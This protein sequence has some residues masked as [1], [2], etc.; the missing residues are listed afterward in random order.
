MIT[1]ARVNRFQFKKFLTMAPGQSGKR[2][3][4]NNRREQIIQLPSK[5]A[6]GACLPSGLQTEDQMAG[7][8]STPP[9]GAGRLPTSKNIEA[10][11]PVQ[12]GPR[13]KGARKFLEP[14]LE[15]AMESD[16]RRS[17]S[18]DESSGNEEE[19]E[20]SDQEQTGDA[21]NNSGQA[22]GQ[23]EQ[24]NTNEH[25]G[26]RQTHQTG[27]QSMPEFR[28]NENYI[29]LKVRAVLQGLPPDIDMETK[30]VK[31][32][33]AAGNTVQDTLTKKVCSNMPFSFL[34]SCS[35]CGRTLENNVIL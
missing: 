32:I 21:D 19:Q 28:E 23:E 8:L 13:T 18:D 15:S 35:S 17:A 7:H 30:I 20:V 2:Q 25:R 1:L 29:D 31:A 22:P 24:E 6:R 12:T 14:V 5:C 10:Q 26:A 3:R 4:G 33:T 16:P 34:C 9:N 11:P 27:F